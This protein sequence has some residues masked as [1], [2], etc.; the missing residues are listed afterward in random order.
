MALQAKGNVHNIIFD[1]FYLSEGSDVTGVPCY[2]IIWF[3]C[4]YSEGKHS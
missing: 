2:D 1:G 4:K 3:K